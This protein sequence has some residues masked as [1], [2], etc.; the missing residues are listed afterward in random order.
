M[1]RIGG[2]VAEFREDV[3]KSIA[4]QLRGGGAVGALGVQV[5]RQA[6]EMVNEL[7]RILMREAFEAADTTTSEVTGLRGDL[8]ETART[9][10]CSAK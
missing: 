6:Q 1:S 9:R 3:R 8:G 5:E 4:R 10:R 7:G 2:R